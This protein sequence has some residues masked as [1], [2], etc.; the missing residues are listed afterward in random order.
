MLCRKKPSPV[1][2][3]FRKYLAVF[4]AILIL[5]TVYAELAVKHQLRDVIIRDMQT[6]SEQAVT[7]AVDDFL[8]EHADTGNRMCDITYNN[9]SVAAIS[10]NAAFVNAAK[11][12]IT[13]HAQDRIDRL[14]RTQGISV[15]LGNFTGLVF[16]SNFGPEI[17]FSVDSTQ[18]VSCEFQSSFV[19]AGIN[20]TV[21]HIT[22]TVYVDLLIYGPIRVG[23]TVS[24]ESAFEIA[25][26]V[27]V[28]TVPSYSG[29]VSY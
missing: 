28:G 8:E 10:T 14:S 17:P 18:T 6:L 2:R 1:R 15:R 27:I 3:K 11:T 13:E 24:T 22:I 26:T 25:Q 5:L 9:G 16:L 19:S 21:H 4:L 7:M 29:V 20:Q 12:Y 23:E